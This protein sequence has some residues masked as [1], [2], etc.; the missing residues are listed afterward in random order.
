MWKKLFS[1]IFLL[2]IIN[3]GMSQTAQDAI[4]IRNMEFGFGARPIAMGG[5]GVA[6]ADDYSAIYWNPGGLASLKKTQFMVEFSHLN[7]SNDALFFDNLNSSNESFSRLRSIGLAVPLPTTRGSFVLGF[8]YNFVKDFDDY[9]YFNGVNPLSNGLEFELDDSAGNL[10]LYSFDSDVLQTEEVSTEGGLSQ[11]SF[12]AGMALSPNFDFGVSMNFWRGRDEYRLMFH[13]VD[14]ANIYN[15]FPAD[16]ESYTLNQYL[17]TKYQAFSLKL[18]GM[19]KLNKQMRLG[20]AVEFPTTFTLKE[21]FCSSDKL[22]FD[23]GYVDA[24]D[25]EPGEWEYRVKTPYRFD[26]GLGINTERLSLTAGVSYRDWSQTR[27][28]KPNELLLNEDY[29]ELLMENNSLRQDY[30]E[31]LNYHLG[32]E[33]VLPGDAIFLRGGY[34]VYPSPLRNAP[35]DMDRIYYSGGIGVQV[36]QNVMLD[37]TLLRGTW[38]RKSEDSFTPGSTLEDI[39][40]NR[41]FVG[42]RYNF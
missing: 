34:A 31:V 40:E 20:M 18:G 25:S 6:L 7:F 4:R 39:T 14:D 10:A 16:F 21:T 29:S 24:V 42:I 27:F 41:F 32:G 23:D 30:R 19:F 37:V 17:Q 11:W 8:G 5:N 35:K 33:L 3:L 22:V 15:T 38:S 12:G 28:D 2:F 26:A 36:N 1:W 13:Q 9:L